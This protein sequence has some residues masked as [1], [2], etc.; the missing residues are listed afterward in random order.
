MKNSFILLFFIIPTNYAFSVENLKVC[1]TKGSKISLHCFMQL[2]NLYSFEI[3]I[4]K[5]HFYTRRPVE[6]DACLFIKSQ[7][8]KIIWEEKYCVL[9]EKD[10][11]TGKKISV[12]LDKV[13]TKNQIW[14]YFEQ[15]HTTF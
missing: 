14:S 8:K 7:I 4:Q 10:L 1:F 11:D 13:E 3:F 15:K 5:Y 6:L 2:D 9:G 12:T